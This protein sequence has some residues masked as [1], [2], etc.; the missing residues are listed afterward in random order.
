M[1]WG[2]LGWWEVKEGIVKDVC[3]GGMIRMEHGIDLNLLN[4]LLLR[5]HFEWEWIFCVTHDFGFQKCLNQMV[6]CL[7]FKFYEFQASVSIEFS[8]RGS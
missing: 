5:A 2:Q 8:V 3:K 6:L 7:P 1:S 4:N